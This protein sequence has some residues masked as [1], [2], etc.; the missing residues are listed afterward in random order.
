MEHLSYVGLRGY[1]G[2]PDTVLL[3]ETYSPAGKPNVKQIIAQR[4]SKL[5]PGYMLSGT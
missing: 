4:V 3:P 1:G 5:Q 2:E